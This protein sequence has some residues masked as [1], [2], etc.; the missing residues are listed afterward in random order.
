MKTLFNCLSKQRL[1]SL[2]KQLILFTLLGYSSSLW[3]Q[4]VIMLDDMRQR[5]AA[6]L[7]QEVDTTISYKNDEIVKSTYHCYENKGGEIQESTHREP[8]QL[9]LY[10]D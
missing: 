9:H 2:R 1:E 5:Y 8:N 6:F 3:A 4:Q 7:R 10:A